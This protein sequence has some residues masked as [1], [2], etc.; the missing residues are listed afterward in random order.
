M[1][2]MKR[3]V[4]LLSL[5]AVCLFP[6]IA[7]ETETTDNLK[8]ANALYADGEYRQAALLYEQIIQEEGV[9]PEL[10]YNLGN[11]YYKANEIG[12]SILNYERALRLNPKDK[13]AQHNLELAQTKVIDSITAEEPF[14]VKKWL[15]SLISWLS[16][17]QWLFLS[18]TLF[19]LSIAGLLIFVFGS[20]RGLRKTSF[21]LTIVFLL[22]S[23]F[24]LGFS[25][26]RKKQVTERN[27]AIVM[28]G[29]ISVKSSPD[30]S[31]TDLF[32]LHEG[33]KVEIKNALGEWVEIEIGDGRQGWVQERQIEKI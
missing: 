16:S 9:A 31:G 22:I 4:L 30:K 2:Y 24:S 29:I 19:L 8:Q 17:N 23:L 12:R 1:I 25:I 5:F 13:D 20:S 10:Y 6:I 28:I 18:W 11:S 21:A 7:Q 3:I 26:S 32:E 33:T 15:Q 27:D 14:F